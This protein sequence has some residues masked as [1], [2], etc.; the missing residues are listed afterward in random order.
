MRQQMFN[1]GRKKR[2]IDTGKQLA[3]KETRGRLVSPY[4]H[5]YIS[6]L[7]MVTLMIIFRVMHL[8]YYIWA[9]AFLGLV[10]FA[11]F[12]A[13]VVP[14]VENLAVY[15]TRSLLLL[16]VFWMIS[17]FFAAFFSNKDVS[18]LG[19]A[20]MVYLVMLLYYPPYLL[21]TVAIRFF[22]RRR[23]QQAG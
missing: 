13:S 11:F 12:N 6:L 5:F 4:Y 2:K 22:K 10:G 20:A 23:R 14:F 15:L 3:V 7:A 17:I 8:P 16:I 21:I 9:V 1:V 18:E 19:S